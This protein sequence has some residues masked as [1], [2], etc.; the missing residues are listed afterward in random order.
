MVG[1]IHRRCADVLRTKCLAPIDRSQYAAAVVAVQRAA[2]IDQRELR[3]E[4]DASLV[5]RTLILLHVPELAVHALKK[6][7][8]K[9][10]K[11]KQ[12]N[13]K[14]QKKTNKKLFEIGNL[15]A[16]PIGLA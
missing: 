9:Q 3:F 7:K 11:N 6:K 5:R 14:Q 4:I 8:K 10:Q 12:K 2:R 16:D 15:R 1:R 13:N